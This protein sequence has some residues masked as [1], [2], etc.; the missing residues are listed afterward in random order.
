ML[1][2]PVS[3]ALQPGRFARPRAN[4]TVLLEGPS[5]LRWLLLLACILLSDPCPAETLYVD[6]NAP[7][8]GDG[9]QWTRAFC[10][11]Q[12][13]LAV[14]EPSN[15][16]RV[17]Q[18]L[19]YPDRGE[20]QM[21]GD[22]SA[23]FELRPG[24]AISGG[25]GG[26][27]SEDPNQHDVNQYASILCGDLLDN[28]HQG[29][30]LFDDNSFHIMTAID[31][32]D[33]VVLDGFIIQGGN[34]EGDAWPGNTRGG[35]MLIERTRALIQN[36]RFEGNVGRRG[37]ALLIREAD[38]SVIDCVFAGNKGR[39]VHLISSDSVFQRCAFEDNQGGAVSSTGL[40]YGGAGNPAFLD[41]VFFNNWAGTGGAVFTEYGGGPTFRNCRFI[42]NHASH[43]GGAIAMG[44]HGVSAVFHGCLFAGNQAANGGALSLHHTHPLF[45]YCTLVNNKARDRGGAIYSPGQTSLAL[46]SSILWYNRA[47]EGPQIYLHV[48]NQ[49]ESLNAM[50]C[51]IEGGLTDVALV[52]AAPTVWQHNLGHDL[53]NHIPSF[54]DTGTWQGT[55]FIEGDY[56]LKSQAGH[57]DSI[58]ESWVP[59]AV[60]SPCIDTGDPMS[61]IGLE[62]FPNGGGVNMGIYGGTVEA[63]KSYFGK[64]ICETIV[65]GDLNGDCQVDDVDVAIMARHWVEPHDIEE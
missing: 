8:G 56:H 24:V 32:E 19:Y 55:S 11:L 51:N 28:D 26:L 7:A 54:V 17:A 18:G 47:T 41:C 13:A 36:C 60:M 61:P 52:G 43:T 27:S 50:Y 22:R 59:D 16:I 53:S 12:D 58:S 31:I 65:A 25:Y 21:L 45:E 38:A 30:E 10:H 1:T 40:V 42:H 33:E 23:T 44:G 48:E 5:A 49:G 29:A 62:P 14:A 3:A 15:E 4:A 37:S 9:L 2:S 20:N 35:G 57:W 63:S 46:L 39:C 6:D 64:P 34:A